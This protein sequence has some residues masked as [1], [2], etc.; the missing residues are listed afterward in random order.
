MHLDSHR[1]T[2]DN[3]YP[4]AAYI[5]YIS[6]REKKRTALWGQLSTSQ[7]FY[8]LIKGVKARFLCL[9]VEVRF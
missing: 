4:S 7:A 8:G 3:I 2:Q 6:R 5:P 1:T 9:T